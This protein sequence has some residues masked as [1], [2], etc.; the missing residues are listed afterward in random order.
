MRGHS[1]PPFLNVNLPGS[2]GHKY[3]LCLGFVEFLLLTQWL[4]NW[5]VSK[6]QSS[7]ILDFYNPMPYASIWREGG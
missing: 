2:Y 1:E 6:H 7:I 5:C 4:G 3:S